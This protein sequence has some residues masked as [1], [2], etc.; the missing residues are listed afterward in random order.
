VQVLT[1][2]R[3]KRQSHCRQS[4]DR[5]LLSL[6][7]TLSMATEFVASS[8]RLSGVSLTARS[9]AA[10]HNHTRWL[11]R[12]LCYVKGKKLTLVLVFR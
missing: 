1:Q 3:T 11:S 6:S 2:L 4:R 10:P 8:A 7:R 12:T 5:E 9:R